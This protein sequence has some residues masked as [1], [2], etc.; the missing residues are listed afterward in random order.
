MGKRRSKKSKLARRYGHFS[1]AGAGGA[2][3]R[4]AKD[5]PLVAGAALGASAA[6]ISVGTPV[7]TAALIGAIAGIAAQE[8]TR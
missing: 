5:H 3:K 7:K 6:A 8:S 4:F 2:V 1:M